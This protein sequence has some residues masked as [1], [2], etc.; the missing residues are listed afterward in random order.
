MFMHV[1]KMKSLLPFLLSPLIDGAIGSP[2][3][4]SRKDIGPNPI[5]DEG[6]YARPDDSH[7]LHFVHQLTSL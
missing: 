6:W 1:A 4:F 3:L 5:H 7:M 2:T